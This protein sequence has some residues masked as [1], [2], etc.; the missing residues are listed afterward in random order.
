MNVL[1]FAEFGKHRY[2][3]QTIVYSGFQWATALSSAKTACVITP[4]LEIMPIIRIPAQIK[5]DNVPEHISNKMIQC[6]TYNN[7]KHVTDL[8]QGQA[9]IERASRTS[10]GILTK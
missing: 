10:K 7:I 6:F 4:L 1:H 5:T 8:P 3:H 2:I 9:V